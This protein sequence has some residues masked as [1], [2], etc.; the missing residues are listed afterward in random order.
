MALIINLRNNQQEKL[1]ELVRVLGR[2]EIYTYF[3]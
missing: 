2:K 3:P 1:S